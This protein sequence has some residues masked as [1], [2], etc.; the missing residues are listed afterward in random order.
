[1]LTSRTPVHLL[2]PALG[3]GLL[4]L[5]GCGGGGA[6]EDSGTTPAATQTSSGLGGAID[7]AASSARGAV[8]DVA[9]AAAGAIDA[10]EDETERTLKAWRNRVEDYAEKGRAHAMAANLLGD[11]EL[12]EIVEEFNATIKTAQ[13][14]F[15]ELK[16]AGDSERAEIIAT[17][18][19]LVS[20]IPA[21]D[22]AAIERL[23]E[24]RNQTKPGSPPQSAPPSLGD[25]AGG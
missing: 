18:E 13:E 3:L 4:L 15:R 25:G 23:K 24:I 6:A 5:G 1:M 20:E 11:A 7:D 21:I 22:E 2:G 9:D 12:S 17:I 14:K 19:R 10:A 8:E 16:E